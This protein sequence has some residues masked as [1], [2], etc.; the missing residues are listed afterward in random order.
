MRKPKFQTP[1]GMHDILPEE[2]KYFQKIYDIV[3]NIAIFYGFGKITTPIFEQAELFEKGTGLT[4]DIVQKEM[5]TLRTK[6]GDLLAPR[7]EGTPP[8]VRA[9]LQH[10]MAKLPQPIKLWY[11]GPFFHYERPQAG[12]YRQFYNF[13]FEI[14]GEKSPVIDVQIIQIFYN[15]LKELNFKNLIVEINSLGDSHCRPYYKKLL[16][17]YLRNREAF[18]CANCRRRLKENPLR[19]LDCK[20]ERCKKV[21]DGA[22]QMIDHLCDEC[23]IHFKEVL[24]FLDELGVP[25][26]LSPYLVRG[27]DYY[28]K[29]VFEIYEDTPE[30]RQQGALPAGGRYDNLIKQ[31]GGKDTPACG[32]S[33]GVERMI[34]IMKDNKI[35][36]SQSPVPKIFLAQLGANARREILKLMD[37]FR[38]AKILVAESFSSDSLGSQLRK[39]DRIGVDYALILGQKEVLEKTII[40]REMKTG[41]QTTIKMD[42]I[43]DVMKK[44]LKKS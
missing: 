9:Y 1:T 36:F 21:V 38:E 28:T 31:L 16:V 27:L 29:T 39:A 13:G 34:N 43:I 22:P 42:K 15:I 41:K 5:F 20:D 11:F 3:E 8:T 10:G 26:I 14:L 7:P 30:G 33:A 35:R 2:Q 4:T 6:G 40:L 32:A 37:K 12:R 24:E 44:R 23:K 19:I 17:S 18:L 25:Y